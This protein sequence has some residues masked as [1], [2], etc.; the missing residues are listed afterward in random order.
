MVALG[1]SPL[2]A[3]LCATHVLTGPDV[4]RTSNIDT[5][6]VQVCV[7]VRDGRCTAVYGGIG[8]Y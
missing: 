1:A 5:V 6:P 4:E 8:V 2:A 3:P 7:R